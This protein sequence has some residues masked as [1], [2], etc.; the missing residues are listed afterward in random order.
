MYIAPAISD[1][2]IPITD[3][4]VKSNQNKKG[5]RKI[6]NYKNDDWDKIKQEYSKSKEIFL[7]NT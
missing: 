4:N 5:T 6:Y 7:K 3:Y 1:H 2:E